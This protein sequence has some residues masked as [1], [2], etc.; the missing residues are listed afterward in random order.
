LS[1][2]KLLNSFAKP[3]QKWDMFPTGKPLF[4]AKVRGATIFC[5]LPDVSTRLI[6]DLMFRITE[7]AVRENFP[8]NFFFGKNTDDFKKFLAH[9]NRIPH[10]GLI[11]FPPGKMSAEMK[12]LFQQYYEKCSNIL[13][14]NTVSNAPN[15]AE[16]FADIPTLNIDEYYGGMLAG[17]HL[18]Q[19]DCDEFLIIGEQNQLGIFMLKK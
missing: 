17:K 11:T 16:M 14:L 10:T 1:K 18:R 19:C 5:Y 9:G 15:T 2:K 3:L 7:E 12:E 6:N 13:F 4:S 8:V